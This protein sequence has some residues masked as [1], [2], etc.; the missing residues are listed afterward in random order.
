MIRRG[1][2]W[3]MA[4][5]ALDQRN[6]QGPCSSPLTWGV[7]WHVAWHA[8]DGRGDGR[9]GDGT[10]DTLSPRTP[11][12]PARPA[13]RILREAERQGFVFAMNSFGPPESRWIRGSQHVGRD[14][15][16]RVAMDGAGPIAILE[17]PAG[18][19]GHLEASAG[20]RPPPDQH[21]RPR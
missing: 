18:P 15:I 21:Q 19:P 8:E 3:R 13:R 1:G 6:L 20:L 11:H 7:A 10:Q 5:G 2:A 17:A 12:P 16:G 14:E 9:E 4:K